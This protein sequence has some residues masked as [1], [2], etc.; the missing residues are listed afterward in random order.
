MGTRDITLKKH[1]YKA[2]SQKNGSVWFPPYEGTFQPYCLSLGMN[3]TLCASEWMY[4]LTV[5]SERVK[6]ASNHLYEDANW[7]WFVETKKLS[8]RNKG[9]LYKNIH[10]IWF[11]GSTRNHLLS[12]PN[13]TLYS[14]TWY[15]YY[16]L[17]IWPICPAEV[18][19][20]TIQKFEPTHCKE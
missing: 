7:G 6:K 11:F 16:L 10:F 15:H 8:Q 20:N 9:S 13:L 19:S 18:R 12:H 1:V 2:K 4:T 14:T 3:K 5:F 17:G